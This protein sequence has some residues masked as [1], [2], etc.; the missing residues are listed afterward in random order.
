EDVISEIVGYLNGLTIWG[1]PLTQENVVPP[2]TIPAI[3]GTLVASIYNPNVIWDEYSHKVA[4]AEVEAVAMVADLIGYDADQSG[5][6][7]TFG[8]TGT[9][10]YGIKLALHRLNPDTGERGVRE[11][12]KV[13]TSD[14]SHYATKRNAMNWLGLGTDNLVIVPT[15]SDNSMDLTCLE[16]TICRLIDDGSRIACIVPTVGTTDAFGIDDVAGITALRDRIFGEAD[17]GYTPHVHADAVIGWVWSVFNDYD[18]EENP[19]DF[20][21]HTCRSLSDASERIR[22]LRKA[23]SVGVDFHKTGFA[24]Y[25]SSLF[26]VPDRTMFDLLTREQGAMPYLYQF[27][28]YKPGVYTLESS[29]NGGAILAALANLKLLGRS[30]YQAL[31]GYLTDMAEHLRERFE[32]E[33]CVHVVNDY[34]FGPV[35]LFRVYPPGTDARRAWEREIDDQAARDELVAHNEYNRQIFDHIQQESLKSG[36]VNLS[37]TSAYR[38]TRWGDPIVAIKSFIMSPFTDENSPERIMGAIERAQEAVD[39]PQPDP[40]AASSS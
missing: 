37:V 9:T 28:E 26:L 14:C 31:L 16:D 12:V 6:V 39:E 8:G 15:H 1:H 33:K 7:F 18:F 3:V 38:W 30:G 32:S 17:L 4:E 21:R 24:P 29:R 2:T 36:G 27:G 25:V 23:D 5:G 40:A 11:D 22:G 19:L 10:V 34:N 13:I 20:C 35:T